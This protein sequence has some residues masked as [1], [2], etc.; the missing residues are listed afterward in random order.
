MRLIMLDFGSVKVGVCGGICWATKDFCSNCFRFD[1]HRPIH[2]IPDTIYTANYERSE[3]N[4]YLIDMPIIYA[5]RL[6]FER[7]E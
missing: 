3:L 7:I 2:I 6:D 1:H 5:Y 4:R